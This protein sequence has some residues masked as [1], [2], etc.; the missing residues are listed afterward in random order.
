MKA[1][2]IAQI[3]VL[4][5]EEEDEIFIKSTSQK[6]KRKRSAIT[7]GQHIDD[8]RGPIKASQIFINLDDYF[9]DDDDLHVLNLLPHN[10]PLG[11]RKKPFSNHSVAENGQPSDSHK[12]DPSFVCEICVESK[13]PNESFRIKGC[14]HSYCTDC[15]IKYVASK[16]QESIT[17][18][19]CPVTGCQ[20][21]LEPEYCRNILPQQVFHRWGNALCEAVIPGDQK[22]Y[23]PFK[24]CSALLIDDGGSG[25]AIKESTCPHCNRMFCA[26]CKVPWHAEMKC[27][28]FQNLNEN[29][30]DDIKLKKLAVEMKWKRCPNCGYYVE[31]FRG[32]NII[33]CRCGTSFHYYSRADLSELYPYRPASRQKGFRLKSRDPVR[34]LEYFDFLDLPEGKPH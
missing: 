17:T 3:E 6:G 29:E 9:D 12:N 5:L 25:M 18:I 22:F 13:S 15:I 33:I 27:E 8:Q 11:K 19:G 26:K 4:D 1:Q 30:N 14:S 23:C 34:T 28:D 21:V 2:K 20:G 31:K 16:L 10:T 32:C 7:V 24:D